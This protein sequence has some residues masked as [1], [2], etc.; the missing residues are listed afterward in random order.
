L[1][2]VQNLKSGTKMSDFFCIISNLA[3]GGNKI[4]IM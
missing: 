3:K 4:S 1:T 2:L